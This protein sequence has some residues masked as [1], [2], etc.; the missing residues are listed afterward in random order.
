[1]ASDS[2]EEEEQLQFFKKVVKEYL[3][4]DDEIKKLSKAIKDRRNKF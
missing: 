1:M 3:K 4:L 2:T